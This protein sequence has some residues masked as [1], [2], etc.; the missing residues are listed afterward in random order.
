VTISPG[1]RALADDVDRR[2]ARAPAALVP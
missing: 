1:I 2:Q